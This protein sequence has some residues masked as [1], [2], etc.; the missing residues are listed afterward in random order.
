[1]AAWQAVREMTSKAADI[2]F[3]LS[4]LEV[5][6]VEEMEVVVEVYYECRLVILLADQPSPR[7]D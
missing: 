2:I 4:L 5:L 3:M 7:T 6:E 1:M